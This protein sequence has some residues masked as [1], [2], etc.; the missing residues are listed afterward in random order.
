MRF[1]S[2]CNSSGDETL[3]EECLAQYDSCL[4]DPTAVYA[5]TDCT[6]AYLACDEADNTCLANLAQCKNTCSV[7]LDTCQ[8]SGD[9]A[10]TASC[11]KMY[12]SC[13]F[14]QIAAE[15][16][17]GEDCVG[18]YLSCEE[19]GTA[20]NTCNVSIPSYFSSEE[21]KNSVQRRP[22]QEQVRSRIR[23][24]Q[25]CQ[26]QF[27]WP[28]MPPRLRLLSGFF[29]RQRDYTRRSRLCLQIHCMWSDR[30]R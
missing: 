29:L 16:A 6:S 23:H 19:S 13:L 7:A 20:D 12:D 27:H 10:L 26:Q 21:A 17:I 24:L 18:E 1:Y 2:V 25:H 5:T 11:S 28:S 14:V 4:Y 3:S 15:V 30:H 8:T 9:P 22:M